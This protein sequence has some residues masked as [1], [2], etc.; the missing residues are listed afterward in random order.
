MKVRFYG[1]MRESLGAE[2]DVDL[3]ARFGTVRELRS[4]LADMFPNAAADL[5]QRSRACVADR[6]VME[7]HALT[8]TE[9]VEFLPPLS[10]G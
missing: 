4:V 9:T 6:F 10:G 2:V 1:R 8:G 5:C 7:E 3:P